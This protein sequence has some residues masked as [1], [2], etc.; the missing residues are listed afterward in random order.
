[1]DGSD[2]GF[3]RECWIVFRCFALFDQVF[4]Q[5][6]DRHRAAA[7]ISSRHWDK[8]SIE[9]EGG[10]ADQIHQGDL[11]RVSGDAVR[12]AAVRSSHYLA[13][14]APEKQVQKG[15]PRE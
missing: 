11:A 8:S 1:M 6:R 12:R 7:V 3:S 9:E 4:D 10:H 15:S 14:R 13:A 2:R 5:G